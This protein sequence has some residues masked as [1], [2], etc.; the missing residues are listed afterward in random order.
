MSTCQVPPSVA[1]HGSAAPARPDIMLPASSGWKLMMY[2]PCAAAFLAV[3][4]ISS[5]VLGTVMPSLSNSALL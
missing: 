4:T 1:Y 2:L 5:A 3:S